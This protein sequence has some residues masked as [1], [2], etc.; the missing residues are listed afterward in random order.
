MTV[1]FYPPLYFKTSF[2]RSTTKRRIKKKSCIG[3]F[4]TR[5]FEKARV[6][7]F[8]RIESGAFTRSTTTQ[9][10]FVCQPCNLVN[11]SVFSAFK[12]LGTELV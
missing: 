6:R 3:N 4:M 9:I 11:F 10:V 1:F 7:P 2:R 5:A 8:N 12:V